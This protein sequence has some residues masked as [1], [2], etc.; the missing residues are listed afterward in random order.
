MRKIVLASKSPRRKS[1]L[2]QIGINF[3]VDVSEVDEKK[4]S[5][6]NPVNL[7]KA[8]SFAKAKIIS[9]KHKNALIIGADTVVVLNR[10]IIGK[11]KSLKDAREILEKLSR[12]THVV[13]TGLTVLDTKT[14]K[15]ITSAVKTKVK[16]K[17]LTKE[18]V[19]WYVKT[20]EPMDKAGGYGIQDKGAVLVESVSGDYSNIV[21]LPIH[22]LLEN[23]KKFEVDIA[24]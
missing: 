15:H 24:S 5:H 4:F 18:E 2:K 17:N 19:N 23:L 14:K 11:P 7:A 22:K 8:L 20:G 1:L 16:F 9:K 10:E 3:A 12:K 13:I 21:G 6:S